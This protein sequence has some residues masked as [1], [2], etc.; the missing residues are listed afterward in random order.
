[1]RKKRSFS[2]LCYRSRYAL[3]LL[4]RDRKVQQIF[5]KV[6]RTREENTHTNGEVP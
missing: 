4:N 3:P 5:D 6:R 1:M 2:W